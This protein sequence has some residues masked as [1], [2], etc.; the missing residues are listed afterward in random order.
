MRAVKAFAEKGITPPGV[1]P[2]HHQVR[3]CAVVLAPDVAFKDGAK[4][5]LNAKRGVAQTTV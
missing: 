2:A 3:S 1:D 4:E 5:A